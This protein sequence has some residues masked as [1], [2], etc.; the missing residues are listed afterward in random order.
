MH[1]GI[2]LAVLVIAWWSRYILGTQQSWDQCLTRFLFA[3]L[4]IL[5]NAIALVSMGTDGAMLGRP[6]GT[7]SVVSFAIAC[8]YCSMLWVSFSIVASLLG[9]VCRQFR[10]YPKWIGKENQPICWI[11]I[12]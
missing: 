10:V 6:L 5:S 7:W 9:R 8:A 11:Q 4:L 3:P 1:L 2:L 12:S